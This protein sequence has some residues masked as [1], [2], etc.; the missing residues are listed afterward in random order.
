HP[1]HCRQTQERPC[2][3]AAGKS[4][5]NPHFGRRR[6]G[7]GKDLTLESIYYTTKYMK[8]D[9]LKSYLASHTQG[10]LRLSFD[11]IARIAK[12]TLPASAYDHPAWW[13]N[14]SKSHVQ[15]KAWLEAGYKTENID[16]V[17]K[18]VEFVRVAPE[19]REVREVQQ[20]FEPSPKKYSVH[21]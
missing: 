12:V 10:R 20:K 19:R 1:R 8:Y 5:I 17:A 6:R 9:A 7:R 2:F 3:R 21:P 16:L 15:A 18:Y 13:A 14:D 11:D 4:E